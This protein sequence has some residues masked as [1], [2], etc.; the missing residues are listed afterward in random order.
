MTADHQH[1]DL[2][3][4]D[5][6]FLA[7]KDIFRWP[8]YTGPLTTWPPEWDI[9]RGIAAQAHPQQ[10]HEVISSWFRDA[11]VVPGVLLGPSI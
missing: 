1:T 6:V 3:I 2:G 10:L 8:L 7:S 11:R 4:D 9:K 5:S